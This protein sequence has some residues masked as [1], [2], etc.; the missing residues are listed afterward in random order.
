MTSRRRMVCQNCEYY[1]E[2][3]GRCDEATVRAYCNGGR[4]Y[5]RYAASS[6]VVKIRKRRER[7]KDE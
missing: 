7:D 3:W 6:K 5:E 1:D 2:E 4:Q